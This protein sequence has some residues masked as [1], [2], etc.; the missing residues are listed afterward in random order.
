MCKE[1]KDTVFLL[2][3]GEH[4][5]VLLKAKKEVEPNLLLTIAMEELAE[6]IQ[7][8]SKSIRNKETNYI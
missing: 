8:V 4:K 3:G 2:G 7:Q 1:A 6:L 5:D